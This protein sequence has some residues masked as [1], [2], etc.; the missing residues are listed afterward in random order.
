MKPKRPWLVTLLAAIVLSFTVAHLL[1]LAQTAAQ[2]EFLQNLPLSVPPLYLALSGLL[3]GLAGAWLTLGLW[4]GWNPA[5]KTVRIVAP[6]FALYFWLDRGWLAASPLRLTNWP[7][8]AGLT[9]LLIGFVFALFRL[10]SVNR[11]FGEFDDR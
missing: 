6:L 11:F 2:W 9:V 10:Q 3:W 8:A 1:R 5:L 4:L 7:F